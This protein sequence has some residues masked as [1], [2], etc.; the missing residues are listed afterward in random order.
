M[1]EKKKEGA[2]RKFTKVSLAILLVSVFAWA[3]QPWK[4]KPYTQ[5]DRKEVEQVMNHSPWA[6]M[7]R[8]T[9]GFGMSDRGMNGPE[10]PNSPSGRSPSPGMGGRPP[11]VNSPNGGMMNERTGSFEA[12][13]ISAQTMREALA[14][15]SILDGQMTQ[16][17]A[18]EYLAKVPAN[19]QVALFGPNMSYFRGMTEAD[20]AKRSYLE[21]KS[22][23]K[24]LKPLSVKIV[25][26]P[27]GREEAITF[28]FAK[29][30]NGQPTIGPNEKE[31]DFI[32]K[33]KNF[34]LKF[35]FDPRKM[36]NKAG[37]DL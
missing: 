9:T 17:D 23:H 36:T 4:D 11:T 33:M 10:G 14:R 8:V 12:R 28:D 21:L 18:N 16:A 34:R 27:A 6:Q 3:S 1:S 30:A 20:L 22:E 24:K 26:T 15:V 31:I 29:K 35:H 13:W 19:Y 7:I 37:R 32:C 5:W 2:M 25:K